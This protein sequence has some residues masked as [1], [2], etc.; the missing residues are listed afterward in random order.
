MKTLLV[1]TAI[2][3]TWS[4]DHFL[5]FM[6]EWCRKYEREEVWE[7]KPHTIVPYHWDDRSKLKAD[8]DYLYHLHDILLPSVVY[9]LNQYH[10][11]DRS[12]RYWQMIIDPWF[13][14]YLAVIYDRWECI[15]HTFK[16]FKHLSTYGINYDNYMISFDYSDFMKNINTD[17]WNH[18]VYLDIM[19]SYY[20]DQCDIYTKQISSKHLNDYSENIGKTKRSLKNNILRCFDISL[21][22]L[23]S[24]PKYL[25]YK[26]YFNHKALLQIYLHIQQ[27]PRFYV[28]DFSLKKNI[29]EKITSI[30]RKFHHIEFPAKNDFERYLCSR[31]FIDMPRAYLEFYPELLKKV[32]RLSYKPK[33]IITA[34]AHW[35]D[36][37]FKI[38]AAGMMEK[39]SKIITMEHGGSFPPLFNTMDFQ[40]DIS[41]KHVVYHKPTHEKHVQK[42]YN[43]V[44]SKSSIKSKKKHCSVVGHEFPRYSYRAQASPIGGQTLVSL[45]LI[46]D[47]YFFLNDNIKSFFKVKPYPNRGWNT[48]QRLID[49]LGPEKVS[50]KKSYYQFLSEARIVVCTYPQTTF[51]ESM[52]LGLPTILYYPDYLWEIMPQVQPL[53]D[54]MRER[55]I[56]FHDPKLAAEHI[57]DIWQSPKNWWESSNVIEA[58]NEFHN[59]LC[60]IGNGWLDDWV[61]FIKSSHNA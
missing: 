37:L 44:L 31:L 4:N 25:L 24:N 60:K 12:Q 8:Y 38:W 56:V 36:N 48:R 6:G 27:L 17:M 13:L 47:L 16:N 15:R 40:E 45:R 5:V 32:N 9:Q 1:T 34:N 39:G 7:N 35:S 18:F 26:S 50:N 53:L 21:K 41:D 29:D 30:S 3:S 58:R 54:L 28:D 23:A 33:V 52:A 20:L 61:N 10:G 51:A 42:Y 49:R 46:F 19:K 22:K 59:Q 55:N 14:T 43:K 2:E 11:V 57:N